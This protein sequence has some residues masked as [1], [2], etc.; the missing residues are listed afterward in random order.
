MPERS[1]IR[2][3]AQVGPST[4]PVTGRPCA[5]WNVLTAATVGASN[6]PVMPR[7]IRRVA[8]ESLDRPHVEPRLPRL[9]CG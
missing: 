5:V 7:T 9:W 3:R 1:V 4:M 8:E 6:T 2:N